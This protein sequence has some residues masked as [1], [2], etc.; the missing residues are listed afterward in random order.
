[1]R[2]LYIWMFVA[3][4]ATMMTTSCVSP[5][6]IIYFRGA[7][8][9]Y[10]EAQKIQQQ[11]EMRIKP[12]DQIMVKV[13]C[14]NPDLLEV[15]SQDVTMGS[16]G[17]NSGNFGAGGTLGSSYGYTVDNQGYVNL[18]ALNKVKV[19]NMTIDEAAEVI[20]KQIIEA[21]LITDPKVTVRLLNGRVTVIG[22]IGSRVVNLTSE[23]NSIIDVIAQ[24]GDVDDIA[25]RRNIKLFREQDGVRSMYVLDLTSTD[26]FNSPAF[27]VQQNDMIYVE[28]N[29]SK[30][31]KASPFF[32]FLSAGTTIIGAIMTAISLVFLIKKN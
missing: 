25:L 16:G 18:P 5:K 31:I 6:K 24:C 23:R 3:V 10:A 1:M 12:A 4:V 17:N 28:P 14:S 27:Y 32:S 2:K 7:D 22:A 9:L 21:G 8:T 19:S 13:T 11:Y 26:I 29:K 20:E 15:F 30:G